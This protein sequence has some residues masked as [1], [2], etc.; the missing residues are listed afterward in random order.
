MRI[1]LGAGDG[2]T[3]PAYRRRVGAVAVAG[4]LAVALGAVAQFTQATSVPMAPVPADGAVVS[5]DHDVTRPV[6]LTAAS[7][8]RTEGDPM[9]RGR[10]DAPVLMIEYAD[11]NCGYCV[12][13]SRETEPELLRRYIDTGVVR[14]EF[15]NYPIR[16]GN[17]S[18]LAQAA[19]AAG[20]QGRFW[21]F[22]DEIY[23]NGTRTDGP[24]GALEVARAAGVPDLERFQEDWHSGEARAAV[25]RDVRAGRDAG[26]EMTPTFTVNGKVMVGALPMEDFSAEID[27]AARTAR[28]GLR[29]PY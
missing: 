29:H 23:V 25:D 20:R 3:S 24:E 22:H 26:A 14:F 16:G 4:L 11:F 6:G 1:I 27:R 18:D 13:F 21:E 9:A 5:S 8:S 15:R 19:W 28:T 2:P 17:S 7:V 12:R 10:V